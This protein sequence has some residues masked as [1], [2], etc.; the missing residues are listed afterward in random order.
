MLYICI[1]NTVHI[2]VSRLNAV[3]GELEQQVQSSATSLRKF[4]TDKCDDME[5]NPSEQ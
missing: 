1:N 3:S 2:Y 4:A 5:I